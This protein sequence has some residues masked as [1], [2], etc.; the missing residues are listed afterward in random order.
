MATKTY[1][2]DDSN[3]SIKIEL[4]KEQHYTQLDILF[5][6]NSVVGDYKFNTLNYSHRY[7]F[8]HY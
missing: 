4:A 8:H 1:N 5:L 2:I 7:I 6:T 3:V